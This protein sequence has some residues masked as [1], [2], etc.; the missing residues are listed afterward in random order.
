MLSRPAWSPRPEKLFLTVLAGVS[1]PREAQAEEGCLNYA[2]NQLP[3]EGWEPVTLDSRRLL[4][5]RAVR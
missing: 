3:K 2:A 4:L 5:R 1:V